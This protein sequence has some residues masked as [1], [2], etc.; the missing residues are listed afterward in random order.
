MNYLNLERPVLLKEPTNKLLISMLGNTEKGEGI[1]YLIESSKHLFPNK[2]LNPGTIRQSVI[3]NL[4]K[5]GNDL[6]LVQAFAGHKYPST[7]EN[8]KQTHLEELKNQVL[9]FHPLQ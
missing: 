9:K 7:T 4:L 1:H 6:R 5:S 3:Y 8:Y 2:K